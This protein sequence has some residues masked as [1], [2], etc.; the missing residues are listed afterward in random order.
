M[1]KPLAMKV[2]DFFLQVERKVYPIQGVNYI[3]TYST[4]SVV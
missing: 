2:S 1:K 3:Y 4:I